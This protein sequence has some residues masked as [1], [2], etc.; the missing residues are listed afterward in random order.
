MAANNSET[1]NFT[2]KIREGIEE[3]RSE[4]LTLVKRM[5]EDGH[6]L[7]EEILLD[8]DYL[9]QMLAEYKLG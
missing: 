4:M 9:S 2:Q 8:A 5:T 3:G 6:E 1:D 7:D